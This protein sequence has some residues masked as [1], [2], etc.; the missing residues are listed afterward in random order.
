MSHY[1]LIVALPAGSD[2][3]AELE[4]RLDPYNENNTVDPYPDYEGAERPED[5][6]WYKSIQ[7]DAKV[8][9]EN[10]HSKILPY[11]PDQLGISSASSRYTPEQQWAEFERD[12][13]IF[14]SLPNPPTWQAVCDAYNARWDHTELDEDDEPDHSFMRYDAEK[15]RAYTL[16]TYNPKSK[17]D[18]WRVGGRWPRYFPVRRPLSSKWLPGLITTALSWEWQPMPGVQESKPDK[19]ARESLNH[20]WVEGG[21]KGLLDFEQKRKAEEDRARKEYAEFMAFVESTGF[22]LEHTQGRSKFIEEFEDMPASDLKWAARDR[23]FQVYREQPLVKALNES[24]EYRWAW[25]CLID[26]YK[27]STLDEL[28]EEARRDAVPGYALLTLD[29]RWMAPGEMGWFGMSTDD[30]EG[31]AE[32]KRQANEYLD[33]LSDDTILVVLDLHI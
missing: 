18:Y 33:N 20:G 7:K 29:E 17:W 5:F 19:D 22:S 3:D 6:W 9:A 12:A 26:K 30:E 14:N 27:K 23:A 13:A 11:E 28:V 24:A 1:S 15:D 25:S 16:S 10:D 21:P 4:R 8:V 31:R 2:V 32:Y